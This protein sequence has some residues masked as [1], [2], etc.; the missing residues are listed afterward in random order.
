MNFKASRLLFF[1]LFFS[2]FLHGQLSFIDNVS[3][4]PTDENSVVQF[5]AEAF[6]DKKSEFPEFNSASCLKAKNIRGLGGY[7]TLQLFRLVSTCLGQEQRFIVKEPRSGLKES[8]L[9]HEIA[10]DQNLAQ[11]VWPKE[12]PGFP[13]LA[14]PI[15]YLSFVDENG[16]KR[17]ILVM[18]EAPGK[19][20]NE[21]VYDYKENLITDESI[22]KTYYRIGYELAN[23]HSLLTDGSDMILN[24]S[25]VHG[26][27]KSLN[28]FYDEKT[29]HSTLI[30]NESVESYIKTPGS[31]LIDIS[32]I[33]FGHLQPDDPK[34]MYMLD[35]LDRKKWYELSVK[36][37]LEGY[38]DALPHDKK[39]SL[40]ELQ[41]LMNTKTEP[42]YYRQVLDYINPIFEELL[43][44][45]NSSTS[46]AIN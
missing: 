38:V 37:F 15:A 23:F 39:K 16:Q 41:K 3:L 5:I 43:K 8:T 14:L 44:E 35:G 13:T 26:D 30:D 1:L 42:G 7:N 22:K 19:M 10:D 11:I 31:R 33:L 4:I 12:K 24:K 32:R 21:I 29:D 40:L 36:S 2:A 28:I 20:L 27:L 9:L 17:Y 45:D 34:V 46:Q 25:V 6:K 18:P